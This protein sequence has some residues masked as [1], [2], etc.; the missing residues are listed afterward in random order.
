MSPPGPDRRI[1]LSSGLPLGL[2]LGAGI[3]ILS[4]SIAG[5]PEPWDSPS[6]V[7]IA[8]LIG[9]GVVGGLLIPGHWIEV[10]VGIF[11]GQALVLLARVMAEPAEGGLWPLGLLFVA[12]YSLLAL[13][14]AVLGAGVRRFLGP[15]G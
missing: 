6:Q 5:R 7:Y 1:Q 9:A 13:F 12:I 3:W 14:G 15:T 8:E 2:A 4:G 11:T 10:A